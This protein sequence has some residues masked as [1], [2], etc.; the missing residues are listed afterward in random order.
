AQDYAETHG[1]FATPIGGIHTGVLEE[2]QQVVLVIPQVLREGFIGLVGFGRIDGVQQLAVQ[3]AT[4][5]GQ[6]VIAQIS[7][8]VPIAQIQRLMQQFADL[9]W[10]TDGAARGGF[11]KFMAATQEVP[12][13]LL[14]LGEKKV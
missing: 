11:Q 1:Q 13:T 5:D 7:S 14:V 3:T 4:T 6:T 9:A 10:E 12:K 2:G 8:G